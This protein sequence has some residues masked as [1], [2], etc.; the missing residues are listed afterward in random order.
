MAF[1]R[2]SSIFM[3]MLWEP[4]SML[5]TRS[6]KISQL[7]AKATLIDCIQAVLF[8]CSSIWSFKNALRFHWC[9][10]GWS[11]FLL[12]FRSIFKII[13][14]W[15][16]FSPSS[17][18]IIKYNLS[19]NGRKKSTLPYLCTKVGCYPESREGYSEFVRA[20]RGRVF[21]E[22]PSLSRFLLSEVMSTSASKPSL[23]STALRRAQG[24]RLISQLVLSLHL[25]IFAHLKELKL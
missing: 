24:F 4:L 3:T 11:N 2:C 1:I 21:Y 13:G 15:T 14:W 9:Q 7:H 8:K 25:A 10:T 17:G 23:P 18:I 20:T 6:S 22:V 5:N 16:V 12:V 19:S